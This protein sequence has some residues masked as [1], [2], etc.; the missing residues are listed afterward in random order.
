MALHFLHIFVL[1]S[2]VFNTLLFSSDYT[3]TVL[4]Q[5]QNHVRIKFV[6]E[7][8]GSTIVDG[9]I[10]ATYKK[11]SYTHDSNGARIPVINEII[12][13]PGKDA[14]LSIISEK[15]E[16]KIAANYYATASSLAQKDN[17]KYVDLKYLGLYRDVALY[18]L[19]ILPVKI[20][21]DKKEINW[22]KELIIEVR[23]TSTNKNLKRVSVQKKEK[24]VFKNFIING[25][26]DFYRETASALMQKAS[27]IQPVFKDLSVIFKIKVKQSGLY[28]ISYSDLIEADFPIDQVQMKN[29]AVY[30]KGV[31]IPV[32]IES[33]RDGSFDSNDYLEFW[34]KKNENTFLKTYEDQYADPFSDINVYW[35][36]EKNSSGLRMIEESGGIIVNNPNEFVRASDQGFE[37]TIHF[38]KDTRWERFGHNPEF[39]DHPVYTYDHWFWGGVISSP[40]T[41]DYN[42]HLPHPFPVGSN[43]KLETMFRGVSIY[44][45]FSNP[46][47]GHQLSLWLNQQPAGEVLASERWQG[48]KKKKVTN[49]SFLV[50]SNLSHGE[51]TLQI[52]MN[53]TGVTDII[54]LNWFNITY[55]RKFRADQDFIKFRLPQNKFADSRIKQFE[56]DGFENNKIEIYKLGLSKIVNGKIDFYTDQS[57]YSSYRVTFQD[58]IF[59]PDVEY[60]AIT[61]DAKKKPISIEKYDVWKENE[62]QRTLIAMG[63]SADVL[64]ITTSIFA[65]EALRL[66]N[67]KQQNGFVVETVTVDQ[68][69]DTFNYGIKSPLAIK[70]FFKYVY[71]FWDQTKKLRYVILMGDGSYDRKGIF[72]GFSDHVPVIMY[73][74]NTYGAAPA[75]LQYATISGEDM[76]PDISIGRIPASTVTDLANYIDKIEVYEN[77]LQPGLWKNKALF[78][79]GNDGSSSDKE[80][81]TNKPI[82]RAQ[83]TRLLNLKLPQ[84]IFAYKLNTVENDT[85]TS[86]IDPEF[87]STIELIDYIDDG[88]SFLNFFGH[89]GGAIWADKVLFDLNDADNLNNNGQYP[90]CCKYDLF[91]RGL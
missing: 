37:E 44:N 42:F 48:Q 28:K 75:D 91:Y 84:E 8:P 27:Q 74:T 82:F 56:I 64:I 58:Q 16:K 26:N 39:I 54:L 29:L 40:S 18:S 5:D 67:L 45:S 61:D 47:E 76:I 73:S 35:L 68:I 62:P 1:F 71:N 15:R 63:N 2:I 7:S 33:H 77:S 51:N 6:F 17:S 79:S 10:Y 34:G 85:I 25:N 36:V 32:Y 57:Q 9:Q 19:A 72:G 31:E 55:L 70:E 14:R 50:Q 69:Y 52:I 41:K 24:E 30:N 80:V 60:I 4:S 88:L 53:Q 86:G 65:N 59:D 78:V 43:V 83:N 21:L 66:E 49:S 3:T 13:L 22:T 87:G 12:H 20:D 46:I 11:S 23:N 81:L 90:F 38:E 89:G